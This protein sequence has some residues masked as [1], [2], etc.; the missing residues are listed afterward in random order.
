MGREKDAKEGMDREGNGKRRRGW[1]EKG[2]K[3]R[4]G[5]GKEGE[6]G[7]KDEKSKS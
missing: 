6:N 3:G 5:K 7:E 1:T 2:K 4:K